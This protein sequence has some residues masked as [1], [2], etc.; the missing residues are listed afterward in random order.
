MSNRMNITVKQ[1]MQIYEH[2]KVERSQL[3]ADVEIGQ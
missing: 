1:K 3:A 2:L